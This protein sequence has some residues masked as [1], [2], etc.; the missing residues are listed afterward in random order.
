MTA[1]AQ[2][3]TWT[4][5]ASGPTP[6]PAPAGAPSRAPATSL[7]T[8]HQ[9]RISDR[10]QRHL[11]AD[12]AKVDLAAVLAEGA[13]VRWSIGDEAGASILD[14]LTNALLECRTARAFRDPLCGSYLVRPRS[15][16]V[17]L[18]PDCER[19]RS[20]RFVHRLAEIVAGMDRA[21]LWTLT[22]PN[23]ARGQLESGVAVLIEAFAALRRRAIFAGGPCRD[24]GCGHPPHR[25]ALLDACRCA[26]CVACRT[27]VH[28]P[29][30]GGVYSVE[31][32]WRP[33]RGDWHPHLHAL[34]DSPWILQAEMR[35]AWR[36]ATCDATRRAER[37]AEGLKGRLPKCTHPHDGEGRTVA[38][39]R[40]ASMVWVNAVAGDGEARLAAIRETLKY[41]SK[42]LLGRDG[43]VVRTA[44]AAELAELI[45]TLRMRRLVAGWGTFRHVH[46]QAPDE[47]EVD[48]ETGEPLPGAIL[49]GPDVHPDLRG[50]PRHCPA[51]GNAADWELPIEVPRRAARPTDGGW[52]VWR[53]PRP[54]R[55]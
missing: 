53:P 44:G 29:V 40:G 34:T 28:A 7:D 50:L 5:P 31:I 6:L 33:E 48:P 24:H 39:C 17:R 20:G 37:R 43:R 42:G 52:L 36:A 46:D 3:R 51:C 26:R 16:H 9:S 1:P 13:R 19:S 2:G 8:G 23:V 22:I 15:C 18:C 4:P 41:V 35:N 27:C 11:N 32:T 55:A 25:K 30:R 12:A 47:I 10:L 45:L 14:R 54:A 49:A 38:P 21:A